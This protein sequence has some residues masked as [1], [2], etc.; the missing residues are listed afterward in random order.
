MPAKLVEGEDAHDVAAYVGSVAGRRGEDSGLLATAVKEAG[1]G[2]PA[3][4]KDG[5]LSI[6]A[7]P[8]GQLAYVTD[9]AQAPA[10]PIE[11]EMPNE[12]TTPH[13]LADRGHADQDAGRDREHRQGQRRAE[14]RRLRVLLLGPRPP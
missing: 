3:V 5:V 6:A 2:E 13:D 12:S 7:D 1:G 14:R 11:V 9:T 8:G 4:A 10:G